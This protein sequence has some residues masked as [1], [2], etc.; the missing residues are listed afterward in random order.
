MPCVA[1]ESVANS[2]SQVGSTV[3][4]LSGRALPVTRA[5]TPGGAAAGGV[6]GRPV[7]AE[8]ARSPVAAVGGQLM[9]RLGIALAALYAAFLTVWLAATRLRSDARA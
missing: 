5:A 2:V 8:P 4:R 9:A 3:S 6:G 1:V 7:D